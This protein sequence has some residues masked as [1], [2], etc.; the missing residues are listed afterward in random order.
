MM[1]LLETAPTQI[2]LTPVPEALPYCKENC[3]VVLGTND[4]SYPA[5]K[6]HCETNHIPS[7]FI[8][9]ADHSLEI[10]G[11]PLES[12]NVLKQVTEFIGQ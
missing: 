4:R 10:A 5:Y 3:V 7:L 8:E 11:K 2:F 9:G 6:A 12:I 1:D